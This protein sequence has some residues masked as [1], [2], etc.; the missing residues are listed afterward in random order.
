MSCINP[1]RAGAIYPHTQKYNSF[2]N[3]RSMALHDLVLVLEGGNNSLNYKEGGNNSLNYKEGGNNS[4]NY[5]GGGNNSL[6]YNSSR[7]DNCMLLF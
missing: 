2:R 1:A 3:Q 7:S 6:N 5:K 4:L